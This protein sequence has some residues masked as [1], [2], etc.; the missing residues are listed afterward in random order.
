[1]TIVL[2]GTTG[3]TTPKLDAVDL[4][5]GSV[6]V[7]ERGSNANGEYVRFAD[8]TQICRMRIT[9][10]DQAIDSVYGSLFQGTRTW[11]FPAV[12]ST[13]VDLAA[14]CGSFK[15]GSGAAWSGHAGTSSGS[16]V[17]LRG[18]DTSSRPVGTATEI[19]AIAIGRWY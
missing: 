7:V 4:E 3:I 15:W 2:N 11:T 1:M 13:P 16:A 10:T 14:A 12:F 19:S 17:I 9:V 18:G 8:G 5:L 6:N